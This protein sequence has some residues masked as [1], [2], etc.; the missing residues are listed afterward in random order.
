MSFIGKLYLIHQIINNEVKYEFTSN[1]YIL[2][3]KKME[4]ENKGE[5][6][7]DN[8]DYEEETPLEAKVW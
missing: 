8:D 4:K 3:L 6:F 1:I 2:N 7:S 5:E